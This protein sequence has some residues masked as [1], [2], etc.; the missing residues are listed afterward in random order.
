MKSDCIMPYHTRIESFIPGE[1][2][3]GAIAPGH[4]IKEVGV[5]GGRTFNHRAVSQH[6]LVAL[7]YVLEQTIPGWEKMTTGCFL[8]WVQILENSP[9][10]ACLYASAH[11]KS[12]HC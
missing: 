7:A 3:N 8:D 11:N 2:P 12:S 10:A 9:M 1:E 5:W 6:Q 4:S